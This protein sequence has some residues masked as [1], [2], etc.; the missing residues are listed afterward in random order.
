MLFCKLELIKQNKI[1]GN[2]FSHNYAKKNGHKL[3]IKKIIIIK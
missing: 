3:K 1:S 2:N